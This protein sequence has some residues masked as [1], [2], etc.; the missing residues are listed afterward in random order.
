MPRALLAEFDY[1]TRWRCGAQSSASAAVRSLQVVVLN[2]PGPLPGPPTAPFAQPTLS[3]SGRSGSPEHSPNKSSGVTQPSRVPAGRDALPPLA[4]E[5]LL[6]DSPA[7]PPRACLL[8]SGPDLST[9]AHSVAGGLHSFQL[10]ISHSRRHW[11]AS[12]SLN[13]SSLDRPDCEPLA[14]S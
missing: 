9:L 5:D 12:L 3:L 2:L 8:A 7:C 11:P 13:H 1:S 4:T 14:R 10:A 6:T